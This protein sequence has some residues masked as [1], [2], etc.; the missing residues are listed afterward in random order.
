M[1]RTRPAQV[2]LRC[3]GPRDV[4]HRSIDGSVSAA[5]SG[6]RFGQW[7]RAEGSI[8]FKDGTERITVASPASTDRLEIDF[9]NVAW[10]LSQVSGVL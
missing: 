3:A 2:L 9:I 4:S 5:L 6:K 7:P 1:P 10:P 8:L